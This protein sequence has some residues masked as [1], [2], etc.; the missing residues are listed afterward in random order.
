MGSECIRPHS[1]QR[2]CHSGYCSDVGESQVCMPRH[3]QEQ[4]MPC[5]AMQCSLYLKKKNEKTNNKKAKRNK[6]TIFHP[7][8]VYELISY[9]FHIYLRKKQLYFFS[10]AKNKKK[11]IFFTHVSHFFHLFFS[12]SRSF[13]PSFARQCIYTHT[14]HIICDFFPSHDRNSF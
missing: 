5:R 1:H 2:K 6:K 13:S 14:Y 3:E 9:N 11:S 8:Y 10:L 7:R 4:D 12:L